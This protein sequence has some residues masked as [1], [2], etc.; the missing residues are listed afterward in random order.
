MTPIEPPNPASVPTDFLSIRSLGSVWMLPMA[1]WKPNRTKETMMTNLVGV[2]P[3]K[4]VAM[5]PR[6]MMIPAMTMACFLPLST[7]LVLAIIIPEYQPPARLPSAAP[8]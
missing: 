7:D 1:N 5:S 3:K 2:S 8:T 6:N 4:M